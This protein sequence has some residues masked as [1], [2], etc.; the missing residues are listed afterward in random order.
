MNITAITFLSISVL[1]MQGCNHSVIDAKKTTVNNSLKTSVPQLTEKDVLGNEATLSISEDDIQSAL[2]EERFALPINSSIILVQSGSRA[3]EMSM[4]QEMSKYFSISTFSGIPE[5]KK[6]LA[7][8]KGTAGA[9]NMNYM[10][11]LRYIAAK[12]KQKAILV[13]WGELE[14]GRYDTETK[15]VLWSGYENGKPTGS[16]KVLRYLLRFAL[17]NVETGEWAIYSPVNNEYHIAAEN[18]SEAME[19]QIMQ[20]RQKTYE[21]TVRDMVNRYK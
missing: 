3:P 15:K 16:N 2:N 7:C 20:L 4:Q 9:E 19:Q 6:T 14:S 13:Y 8:N 18:S 21:K 12:G 11:A 5:R 17:V 10:Q 1:F